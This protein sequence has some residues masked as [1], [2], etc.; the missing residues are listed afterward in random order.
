MITELSFDNI[1]SGDEAESLFD[2]NITEENKEGDATEVTE[3]KEDKENTTEVNTE[4]LFLDKPESVGSEEDTQEGEDTDSDKAD[5]SSP[6]TNVYSFIATAFRDEGIFP[7][8]DDDFLKSIK[9]PE[10]FAEAVEKQVQSKLDD[11]QRRVD[12]AL[13]LNV[14][15]SEINR[16]EN[17]IGYLDS[18]EEDNISSETEEG[19]LLRKQLIQQDYINRGFSPERAE[20]EASKSFNAGTDI[21]DAKEALRSN[22]EYFVKSYQGLVDEAKAEREKELKQREEEAEKLKKSLLEQEEVFEGITL[23]KLTRQRV[24]DNL[25]KPVYT[26][27]DGYSYT[28]IQKYERENKQEFMKKL[29]VIFTLTDGFKNLDGLVKGQVKKETKRN[30]R[31]LEHVLKNSSKSF[32]GPLEFM[33]GISDD[34]ES[35]LSLNLDI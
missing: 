9:T 24:W 4:T 8:L 35:T 26:D 5:T 32:G 17:L 7:D 28:A 22:K 12:E 29:G 20:K 21:E 10:D 1:L 31:E 33:S 25:T 19:E 3:T 27:K 30:L 2:E 13:N 34:P 6:D 18:I 11:R 15:V 23:N 16:Y 14:E